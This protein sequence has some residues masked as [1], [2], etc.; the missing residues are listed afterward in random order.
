MHNIIIFIN[1]HHWSEADRED[2]VKAR[3]VIRTSDRDDDQTKFKHIQV[4]VIMIFSFKQ[5]ST[6]DQ[7]PPLTIS[8]SALERVYNYKYLGVTLT[9]SLSWSLHIN[10]IIK[11][12]KHLIGL[13]YHNFYLNSTS[14]TLL[15]CCCLFTKALLRYCLQSDGRRKG[16][17][18][19]LS[20][21]K[22]F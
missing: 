16:E 4:Q 19:V 7:L 3:P 22:Y 12:A 6:F 15:L 10:A 20:T 1:N 5:Q 13:V 2:A 17:L 21:L 8:G 11:K 14:N 9:C 18:E